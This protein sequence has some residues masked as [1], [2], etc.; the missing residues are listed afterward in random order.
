MEQYI[1]RSAGP[2]GL[3]HTWRCYAATITEAQA[4]AELWL[5]THYPTQRVVSVTASETA[6]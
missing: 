6:A 2:F 5:A 1:V 4:A 3:V